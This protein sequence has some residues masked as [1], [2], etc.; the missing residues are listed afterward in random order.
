MTIDVDGKPLEILRTCE[1]ERH[2]GLF[3]SETLVGQ[4]TECRYQFGDQ[5][6]MVRFYVREGIDPRLS[7]LE[8]CSGARAREKGMGRNA[9]TAKGPFAY[10]SKHRQVLELCAPERWED[11]AAIVARVDAHGRRVSRNAR[12]TSKW[13]LQTLNRCLRSKYY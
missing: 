8:C 1:W 13:A 2:A 3:S 11:L 5:S 12:F 4:L 6:Y 9:M 10:V 7:Y